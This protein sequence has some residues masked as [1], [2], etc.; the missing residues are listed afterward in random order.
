M[1]QGI[2]DLLGTG[3]AAVLEIY[4]VHASHGVQLVGPYSRF[5]WN[6]PGPAYFY[7]ALP[8]Y[9]ALHQ[10]SGALYLFAFLVNL[11]SAIAIV[12]FARSLKGDLFA[13]AV[14]VL[15]GIYET[16]GSPVRLA[17]IWNPSVTLLPFAL[18]SFL[19]AHVSPAAG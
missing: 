12:W 6:H 1:R 9:Q 3:D 11:A 2:P 15:L 10:K 19:A 17:A 16:Q 5:L 13:F 14:A 18:L 4:T 8:L 7:L